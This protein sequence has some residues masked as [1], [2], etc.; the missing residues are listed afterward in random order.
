VTDRAS[1]TGRTSLL[2]GLATLGLAAG[3]VLLIGA[4]LRR[5]SRPRPPPPAAAR[6]LG[7]VDANPGL[8]ERLR[9]R[10][11]QLARLGSTCDELARLSP[12]VWTLR[13][14]DRSTGL[15]DR[16]LAGPDRMQRYLR[17][18]RRA[19]KVARKPQ[20]LVIDAL[21]LAVETS[22]DCRSARASLEDEAA[23]L[24]R[25]LA[26]LRRRPNL[27]A[28]WRTGRAAE[29]AERGL[30]ELGAPADR[31]LGRL[32]ETQRLVRED[33][34]AIS[35][36]VEKALRPVLRMVDQAAD[37]LAAFE[38]GLAKDRATLRAITDAAFR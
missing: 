8:V 12:A 20:T 1:W 22:K 13:L 6:I 2:L 34:A 16:L 38:A 3:L 25:A 21:E 36:L 33:A 24:A 18:A 17:W 4:G 30:A 27:L 5:A 29:A 14:L 37:P 10:E 15:V 26:E 35:P 28:V 19:I 32:R 23:E 9:A 31:L 7:I 11:Q